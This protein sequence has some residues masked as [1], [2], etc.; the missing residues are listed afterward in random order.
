VLIRK[1]GDSVDLGL[2]VVLAAITGYV[3][4]IGFVCLFGVFPA[5]QSGNV[6]L[7]GIALGSGHANDAWRPA[8]AMA[9]FAL[10]VLVAYRAGKRIAERHRRWTLLT[11]E[12]IALAALALVAG[13][14]L[15]AHAP[16]GGADE[17]V[18]LA[19]ASVAMGLQTVALGRVSGVSV[20]TTYQTGAIVR[21]SESAAD[22][23]PGSES[24]AD[25]RRALTVLAIVIACYA[26]GAALG[27][28]VAR[29]W[30]GALWIAVLAAATCSV[31]DATLRSKGSPT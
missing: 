23:V 27:A 13:D 21:L 5:N 11:V 28:L 22:A 25:A 18:A 31:L 2:A 20:S 30:G 19:L 7:F 24:A 14:V 12:T 9:G 4:A 15:H 10:G 29:H 26:G 3:D 17:V 6:V 16:M 8:L 1:R